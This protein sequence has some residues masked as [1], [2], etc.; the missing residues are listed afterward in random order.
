MAFRDLLRGGRPAG[1]ATAAGAAPDWAQPLFAGALIPLIRRPDGQVL[2]WTLDD[3][4]AGGTITDQF[5]AKAEEYH[6]RYA[7]A[8]HFEKLFREGVDAA[9][10]TIAKAPLVLDLGS[11]SGVNSVVPCRRLYPGARIV[12]TDLSGEL[13]AMLGGYGLDSGAA[14]SL[15]CVK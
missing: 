15:V 4:G 10:V 3:P 7:A 1:T 5:T 2:V 11:G 12:A 9:G 6:R 8:A 14:D 13:L